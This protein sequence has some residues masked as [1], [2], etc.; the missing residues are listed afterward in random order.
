MDLRLAPT[1]LGCW[2]AA[3]TVLHTGQRVGML[4]CATALLA[5]A[6]TAKMSRRWRWIALAAVVGVICG[7]AATAARESVARAPELTDLVARRVTAVVEVRISDDP[8]PARKS[9]GTAVTWVVP[10]RLISVE[11]RLHTDVRVLVLATEPGWKGFL[12]GQRV[13]STVRFGASRGGDLKAAVLSATGQPLALGPPS[14]PQRVAAHL[15]AGLQAAC[16]PLDDRPGGLLPGLVVGDTSRLPAEVEQQFR[17]VG[18][19][20]LNAVSGHNVG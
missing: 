19:T 7:G 2:A 20:H 6:L 17:D 11:G 9:T 12:P 15:R 4:L 13:R 14:W 5:G 3:L 10:A 8:R 18:L 1:A 16:E